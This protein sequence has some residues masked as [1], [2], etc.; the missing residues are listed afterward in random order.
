MKINEL[1][2]KYLDNEGYESVDVLPR[3][4]QGEHVVASPEGGAEHLSLPDVHIVRVPDPDVHRLR[5][6]SGDPQ[7]P[8]GD[9]HVLRHEFGRHVHQSR[10]HSAGNR[11]H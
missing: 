10:H 6:H 11:C 4:G 1:I 2:M 3:R 7:R 9:G 8:G 5:R